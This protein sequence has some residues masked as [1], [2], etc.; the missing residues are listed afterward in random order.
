MEHQREEEVH[1]R[2]N[3]YENAQRVK[4]EQI[5]K[6]ILENLSEK[7]K[8][9][10]K[11]ISSVRRKMIA[12]DIQV[13]EALENSKRIEKVR[14]VRRQ[15]ILHRISMHNER[16]A[17]IENEKNQLITDRKL[18][19]E[20]LQREKEHM[21]KDFE[22]RK[23]ELVHSFSMHDRNKSLDITKFSRILAEDV[24]FSPEV[25][26]QSAMKN[27]LKNDSMGTKGRRPVSITATNS[28]KTNEYKHGMNEI[29]TVDYRGGVQRKMHSM[30][31]RHLAKQNEYSRFNISDQD[32]QLL[33]LKEEV[34]DQIYLQ[35]LG[36]LIK[37]QNATIYH[38]TSK[39]TKV[40]I[41]VATEDILKTL[42]KM[43]REITDIKKAKNWLGLQDQQTI[44]P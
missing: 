44:R 32:I 37:E 42:Q 16:M 24:G 18:I 15:Q 20:K 27:T 10:E 39:L 19:Q 30:Q 41:G 40:S 22:S 4:S 35:H 13:E 29:L 2:I 25:T 11:Y 1:K 7:E 12:H 14:E 26:K 17:K 28:P 6:K 9:R 34:E 23:K 33:N 3:A 8:K 5:F 36:K 38:Q 43:R 21:L 31:D